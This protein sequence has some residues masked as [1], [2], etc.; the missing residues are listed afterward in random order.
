MPLIFIIDSTMSFSPVSMRPG[1]F[2][3]DFTFSPTT[4]STSPAI[5]SRS[6]KQSIWSLSRRGYGPSEIADIF[7]GTTA[8]GSADMLETLAGHSTVFRLQGLIG[9]PLQTLVSL[10]FLWQVRFREGQPDDTPHIVIIEEA[11]TLAGKES[12][13]DIG[14]GVPSRM[15]RTARKRHI[16]LVLCDQVPSELPPAIPGNLGCRI[17]MRLANARCV[18]SIQNSMGLDRRQ[19]E[20][21]TSLKPRHAVMHYTPYP[22]P[23]E[24]E[25]PEL[26]F[27]DPPE[28]S[29]LRRQ[30]RLLL[31]R[32]SC[33]THQPQ[34]DT[35]LPGRPK[36]LRLPA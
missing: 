15:F 25:T 11:H 34:G 27:P 32:T 33:H 30:S 13:Q 31:S 14:Q 19:A 26:S 18:W 22:M 36:K 20:T 28:K 4:A 10:L 3:I 24:I 35:M 23:F 17:V 8:V 6:A 12:R 1:G 7:D 16:S 21:V 5:L 9:I 2:Y 29:K